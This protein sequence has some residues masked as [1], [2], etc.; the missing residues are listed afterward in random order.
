MSSEKKYTRLHCDALALI[1]DSGLYNMVMD[2]SKVYPTVNCIVKI[3]DN[4]VG[5]IGPDV[6]KEIYS[7]II[8]GDSKDIKD[9]MS[10]KSYK[11]M[12]YGQEFMQSL[13]KYP[14]EISPEFKKF[15]NTRKLLGLSYEKAF[16]RYARKTCRELAENVR[17]EGVLV[18]LSK[19]D[20]EDELINIGSQLLF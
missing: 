1:R 2:F 3:W 4:K 10:Q 18:Q 16:I 15:E 19:I 5:W 13:L 12:P 14:G 6:A 8:T 9:A 20:D 11:T 7:D 17:D